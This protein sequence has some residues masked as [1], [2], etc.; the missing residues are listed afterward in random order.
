MPAPSVSSRART[1]TSSLVES[2][3]ASAPAASAIVRF[4]SVEAT[5]ITRAPNDRATSIAASPTPPPAPV[6][7][8]TSPGRTTVRRVNANQA[9]PYTWRNDAPPREVEV[10]GEAD[11]LA[12]RRDRHSAKPPAPIDPKT[13]SPGCQSSTPSPTAS[14]T[15]AASPPGTYGACIGNWYL[16]A[17]SSPST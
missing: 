10:G 6:T 12:R 2:I 9:V 5:A 16:P 4:S 7:S 3:A 14:I 15:P 17:T 11:Q 13:R 8:T 1:L